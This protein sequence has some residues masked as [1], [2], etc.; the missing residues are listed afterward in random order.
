MYIY[1]HNTIPAFGDIKLF[2]NKLRTVPVRRLDMS[3]IVAIYICVI[4]ISKNM[5]QLNLR[6]FSGLEPSFLTGV[7]LFLMT[8]IMF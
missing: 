4:I 5:G 2:H 8:K 1:I 7:E 6:V 3:K